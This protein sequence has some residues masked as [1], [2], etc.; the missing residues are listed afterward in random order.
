MNNQKGLKIAL[1]FA[2]TIFNSEALELFLQ[3]IA[4]AITPFVLLRI[5]AA[6]FRGLKKAYM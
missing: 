6:V 4:F 3:I 2:V 1:L 5:N